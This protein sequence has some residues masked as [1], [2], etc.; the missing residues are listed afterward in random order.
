MMMFNSPI[1]LSQYMSNLAYHLPISEQDY[2][3]GEKD[4]IIKHEYI[5]GVVYAMSGASAAHNRLAGNIYLAFANHLK[6]KPC[7][8]YTSDMKVKVGS[9]YFY[10]DVLVD[11]TDL[12]DNSY[13]SEQ[14][15]IIVEVLSKSTRQLDKTTKLDS[16]IQIPSLQ[17]YL[18]IEQEQAEI[19]VLRRATGWR[20]EYYFLGDSIALNSIDLTISVEDIYQRV[21]NTDVV[22]WLAQKAQEEEQLRSDSDS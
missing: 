11:C 22:Q 7:Q 8:P 18:L 16:Y 10:P 2:L 9:K 17:E 3:T 4:S 15:S 19:A 6:G 14:P 5:D 21:K 13:F 12:D 1:Q 20:A